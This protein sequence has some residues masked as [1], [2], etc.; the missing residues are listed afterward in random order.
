[1]ENNFEENKNINKNPA[2]TTGEDNKIVE[3]IG[4]RLSSQTHE[5]KEETSNEPKGINTVPFDVGKLTADQLQQLKSMLAVT[6]ERATT[7]KGN[8]RTFLRNIN[9]GFVI[10]TKPAY[11]ALVYDATRLSEVETHKIPVKLHNSDKWIDIIY[12]DF[13]KAERVPCE[14]LSVRE[15]KGR[16]VEGEVVQR[17][18]GKIVEMEV[19]IVNHF[20]KVKL[21]DG[22]IVEI[23]GSAS[24]A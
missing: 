2:S 16:R 17:E 23:E 4:E 22:T 18:T 8:A 7:K 3:G 5:K 24:N 10:A 21:P 19:V 14:I 9:G 1:M 6:P 12:T 20:F 13:M 11:L 15:E